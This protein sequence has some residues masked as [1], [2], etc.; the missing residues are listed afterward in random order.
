MGVCI[1][2]CKDCERRRAEPPCHSTCADY[3][4]EK[5]FYNAKAAEKRKE[6]E[7]AMGAQDQRYDAIRRITRRM[8]CRK[9]KGAKNG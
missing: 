7:V 4:I 3:I 6:Y 1:K 5:A 9:K 2:C 8:D